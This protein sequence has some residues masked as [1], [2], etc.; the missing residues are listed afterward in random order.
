MN[1]FESTET[2]IE[3]PL[4]Q[5]ELIININ[6]E[7]NGESTPI[8]DKPKNKT[9]KY[10]GFLRNNNHST[11]KPHP[12]SNSND[13]TQVQKVKQHNPNKINVNPNKINSNPN[14]FKKNNQH[15][16]T[17]KKPTPFTI[18]PN[19]DDNE[20]IDNI[21]RENFI[22]ETKEEYEVFTFLKQKTGYDE[23]RFWDNLKIILNSKKFSDIKRG[24]LTLISYATLHDNS[25]VFFKLLNNFGIEISHEEYIN[26]VFKY[27]IHKN[28]EIIGAALDFYGKNF[29]VENDFLNR[30]ISDISTNSYRQENNQMFLKWL[31]PYLNDEHIKS[32]WSNSLKYKNI[33]IMLEALQKYEFATYLQ[34]NYQEYEQIIQKSGHESQFK[35]F[36]NNVNDL[37]INEKNIAKKELNVIINSSNSISNKDFEPKI[38]LS[39]KTDQFK[40]IQENL[41]DKKPTEV[42]VKKRRKIG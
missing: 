18:I 22:P 40:A 9:K 42:I 35:K 23:P 1:K 12:N 41:S 25:L 6:G 21:P 10:N 39:D 13:V 34:K 16:K 2:A 5:P 31:S 20:E 11:H 38:W 8:S 27:G 32:F 14:N 15:T 19:F 36:L 30:F 26:H 37:L 17:H 3:I 7:I 33:P 29:K 24:D 28:P 4:T